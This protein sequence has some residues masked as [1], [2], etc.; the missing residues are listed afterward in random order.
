AAAK[1]YSFQRGASPD[2]R[3]HADK[4][5]NPRLCPWLP[6]VLH[7]AKPLPSHPAWSS[8]RSAVRRYL[9]TKGRLRQAH[10][11]RLSFT[12][13]VFNMLIAS[14][15]MKHKTRLAVN[16]QRSSAMKN[17]FKAVRRL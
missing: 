14:I 15:T 12:L 9:K 11:C 5:R 16:R 2:G 6:A 7:F 1:A 17:S 13:P 8:L 10:N 3:A 4:A